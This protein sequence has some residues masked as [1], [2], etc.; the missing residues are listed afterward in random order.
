MAHKPNKWSNFVRESA[1]KKQIVSVLCY[2]VEDDKFLVIKRSKNDR[3]KAGYWDLPGGHVDPEDRSLESAAVRELIEETGLS[4]PAE[5]LVYIKKIN[6]SGADKYVFATTEFTGDIEFVPNPETG[7]IEHE[8]HKWLKP[9]EI[10]DLKLS[11]VPHYV[12]EVAK[13][14]LGDA[15]AGDHR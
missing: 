10:S 8:E 14:R 4:A 6:L 15:R 7:H 5:S 13:E 11:I 1:E 2:N 9:Q 3:F 12:L